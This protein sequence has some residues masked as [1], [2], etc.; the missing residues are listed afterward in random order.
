M[1]FLCS[2]GSL[3]RFL[4]SDGILVF[5]QAIHED[6][7]FAFGLENQEASDDHA[8]HNQHANQN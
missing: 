7:F 2:S 8:A 6:V 1:A 4:K 3:A 5:F